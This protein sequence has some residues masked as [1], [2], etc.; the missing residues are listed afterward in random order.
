MGIK[1]RYTHQRSFMASSNACSGPAEGEEWHAFTGKTAAPL[2][3]AP[4][5]AGV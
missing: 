5:G 2:G 4:L 1:T 3:M